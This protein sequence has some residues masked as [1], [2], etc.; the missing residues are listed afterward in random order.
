MALRQPIPVE[1]E[2]IDR[3]RAGDVAAWHSFY[4]QHLPL[5]YRVARRMGV[6]DGDLPDVCQEVFLRVFRGLGRFREQ[7][8][9]STWL[10]SI[11]VR[12]A[13]RA[14]RGRAVRN[15]LLAL[16]G[17]QPRPIAPALAS[18]EASLA[19][20]QILAGM[21]PKHREV[22]VLFEWEELSLEEVADA[23]GCPLETVRS[24][25]RRARLEF[26]RLRDGDRGGRP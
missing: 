15:A 17:R 25:L 26:R 13:S 5:V 18:A 4:D 24:R 16:V 7:A 1:H 9:L 11:V 23:L 6:P 3:C 22:F 8:R 21:K 20:E 2:T 19:L 10:Y 14:R 12:E